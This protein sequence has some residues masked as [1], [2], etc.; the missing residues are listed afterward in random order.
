MLIF[1]LVW[2]FSGIIAGIVRYIASGNPQDYTLY[3]VFISA[4]YGLLYAAYI[5]LELTINLCIYL[6]KKV[7]YRRK[8][9]SRFIYGKKQVNKKRRK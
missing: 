1:I 9:D 8:K 2:I 5:L 3:D 6:K 7:I 4:L